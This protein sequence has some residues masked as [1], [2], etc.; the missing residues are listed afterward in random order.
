MRRDGPGGFSL[1]ELVIVLVILSLATLLLAPRLS[2]T[3]SH[4]E[5]KGAAKR[6]SALLRHCRSDAI[7][8]KK[9]YLISFDADA[10]AVSI[11]TL[12]EGEDSPKADRFYVLSKEV[13]MEKVEPG[14]NAVETALP[15]FEFYPNGGSNGG[16]VVLK[17]REGR[18]YNVVVDTLTG[19][20]RVEQGEER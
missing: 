15:S 6:V 20:V 14:K 16:R 1:L 13:R 11:S 19:M 5:T 18:V 12:T 3:I 9:T 8:Q 4:M 2:R 17:G 7:N 10:N